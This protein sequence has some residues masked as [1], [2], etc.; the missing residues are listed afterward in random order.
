MDALVEIHT[1]YDMKKA[2]N[3]GARIIGINNRNLKTLTVDPNLATNMISRIPKGIAVVIESGLSSYDELMMYKSLGA[4][5]F[6]VG[7]SL[8]R[9]PDIAQS[10]QRLLGKKG[11]G[12]S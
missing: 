10:L 6:F 8:I 1:E 9:S 11:P 12:L 2:V 5:A 4:S 7:T 3:A